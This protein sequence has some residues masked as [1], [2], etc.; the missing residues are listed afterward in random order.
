MSLPTALAVAVIVFAVPLNWYVCLRLL[1]LS[2]SKPDLWVL[3][4]HAF[5]ALA[6]AIIV[7]VFGLVFVNNEMK[8]PPLDNEATKLIT[9]SAILAVSVI[10][11]LYWLWLV[12]RS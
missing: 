11:A 3:R 2:H 10:P 6:L 12:R 9:R 5:L 8:P 1:W 4:A 7:T